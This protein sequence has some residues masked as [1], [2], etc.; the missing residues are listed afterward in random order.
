MNDIDPQ[1]LQIFREETSE[2]LDRIVD[3]VLATE[4]GTAP[5]DSVDALFRD[6]HSIKGNAG[7]VGFPAAA[8]IAGAMEDILED[9]REHGALP[10]G[11]TTALLSATDAIRRSIQ[12]DDG[13]PAATVAELRAAAGT[14]PAPAPNGPRAPGAGSPAAIPE[15]PPPDLEPPDTDPEPPHPEPP[16]PEPPGQPSPAAVAELTAAAP[17]SSSSLSGASPTSVRVGTAKIDRL[18]DVVGETVLHRRR[19]DHLLRRGNEDEERLEEELG[20]GDILLADL[21]DSVIQMRT[22]PLS[23]IIGPF[24]RAVR[25][26][27]AETGK[28]AK[29][30]MHGTETQLDRV[31]LDGVSETIVHVLRNAVS[32]GIETPEQ[33]AAAGKAP[34][35]TVEL[36]AEPR[37]GLVAITVSDDGRGVST[38]IQ[39]RGRRAGSLVEVLAEPG[40]S[41]AGRVSDLSGRGVGLDAVK[42]HVESLGGGMEIASE[43][44]RGTAVTLLLPLTLALMELLLVERGGQPFGLPLPS[45]VEAFAIDTVTTLGGRPSIDLRGSTVALID[46]AEAIG[47][48]GEE[49]AP[50]SPAVVVSAAGQ[51]M[52]V[53]CDRLLGDQEAVVKTLGPLLADLPGYLGAAILGDGRVALILEPSFLVRRR[54]AVAAARAREEASHVSR[55]LVVDDQF[56]VREL[57][58]RIL[59]GAGYE[60]LTAANGVEALE[61]ITREPELEL[62][63]TDIE[64][65]EMDGLTLLQHIRGEPDTDTLPVVIVSSRAGEEDRRRGAEAG[66][67]AY[68]VKAEFD[69]R[70][71]LETVGRLIE[72]R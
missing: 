2:R 7:M 5:A 14:E 4:A 62:V 70:A 67:D 68:V 27:A 42:R 50:R 48:A 58:R 44:G 35:G 15:P 39:E 55:V 21:Q 66:A 24:P 72:R 51:R 59:E 22:L 25:D 52:A 61:V 47:A 19:L 33:R 65:P 53:V 18:L 8:T 1:L 64:M 32:H 10:P 40:F 36:R 3:L 57:Q 41:T 38:E 17:P 9:A 54:A 23:S 29:L 20:S 16:H 31:I 30:E 60:V 63:V 69:Q 13:D 28:Q 71:L 49:L 12:G 43:P 46:L 34:E 45:V 6:A 56:T 11:L 26:M 37:G